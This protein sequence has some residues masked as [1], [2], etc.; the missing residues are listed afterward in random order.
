MHGYNVV[1]WISFISVPPII[2]VNLVSLSILDQW[3]MDVSPTTL[4]FYIPIFFFTINFFAL[5]YIF[6]SF[7]TK[8]NFFSLFFIVLLT[9]LISLFLGPKFFVLTFLIFLVHWIITEGEKCDVIAHA[10]VFSIS[11]FLLFLGSLIV[12]LI[13]GQDIDSLYYLLAFPP[14]VYLLYRFSADRIRKCFV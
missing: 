4:Y 3:V 6:L 10:E 2:V 14:G 11:S 1:R 7:L 9:I 13:H 5:C 8:R 12:F